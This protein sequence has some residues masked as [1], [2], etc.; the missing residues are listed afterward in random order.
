MG[1]EQV[2]LNDDTQQSTTIH[3]EQPL[4]FTMNIRIWRCQEVSLFHLL[5]ITKANVSCMSDIPQSLLSAWQLGHLELIDASRW[6][7]ELE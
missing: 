2:E 6:T 7:E 1:R 5:M 4:H 3:S